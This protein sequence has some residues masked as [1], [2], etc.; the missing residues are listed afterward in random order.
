MGAE[1][2]EQYIGEGSNSLKKILLWQ[3]G[4]FTYKTIHP[5]GATSPPGRRPLCA[6]DL[7]RAITRKLDK[8]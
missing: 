5:A 3:R 8:F 4:R 2:S 6:E 1:S 7:C